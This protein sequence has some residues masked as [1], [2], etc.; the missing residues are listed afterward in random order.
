MIFDTAN[1]RADQRLCLG[2]LAGRLRAYPP[3]IQ[4]RARDFQETEIMST[5][6]E[7][8]TEEEMDALI[9]EKEWPAYYLMMK[10]CRKDK[11]DQCPGV[12][13]PTSHIDPHPTV[14]L[15]ECHPDPDGSIAERRAYIAGYAAPADDEEDFIFDDTDDDEEELIDWDDSDDEE[16]IDWDEGDWE[17]DEDFDF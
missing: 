16:L 3:N 4:N 9:A 10:D 12:R 1:G 7:G 14:C 2:C 17:D 8:L 13:Q 15:C 6:G 11:C 5:T